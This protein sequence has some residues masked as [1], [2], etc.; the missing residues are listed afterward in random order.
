MAKKMSNGEKELVTRIDNLK[1]R[2]AMELRD[3]EKAAAKVAL[4]SGIISEMQDALDKIREVKAQ[5][6]TPKGKRKPATVGDD[7]GE[8]ART[9]HG[10]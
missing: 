9:E 10:D 1:T 3:A 5:R 6:N 2:M 7:K 8:T 4:T